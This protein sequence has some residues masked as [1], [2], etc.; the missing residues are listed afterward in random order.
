MIN[1]GEAER[2]TLHTAKDERIKYREYDKEGNEVNTVKFNLGIKFKTPINEEDS[3]F[4]NV[5]IFP[6]VHKCN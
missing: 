4:D 2:C 6:K 1:F 5:S 3:T